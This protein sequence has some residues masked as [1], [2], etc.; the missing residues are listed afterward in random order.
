MEGNTTARCPNCRAAVEVDERYAHAGQ[1][2]CRTCGTGLKVVRGDRLRLVYADVVPLRDELRELQQ[3]I[4]VTQRE[5]ASARASVGIGSSGLGLG[6]L[7]I[8]VKVAW[9]ELPLTKDLIWQAVG[10][11]VVTG[12]LLELANFLFLAKRQAISGLSEEVE[13]YQLEAR[14]IQVR[15]REASRV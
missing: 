3:R 1:L 2:D 7:Y 13:Q 4:K 10:I 9:E 11:A 8:I 5:L 15:I 14:Q 12:I 6:L